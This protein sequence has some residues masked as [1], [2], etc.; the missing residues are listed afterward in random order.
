MPRA[1][2]AQVLF[3]MSLNSGGQVVALAQGQ[4]E[5]TEDSVCTTCFDS[6]CT[7]SSSIT[8]S[9]SS[10][11]SV[12]VTS[13]QPDCAQEKPKVKVNNKCP[14][15]HNRPCIFGLRGGPLKTNCF[16]GPFCDTDILEKSILDPTRRATLIRIYRTMVPSSQECALERIPREYKTTFFRDR[17]DNVSA[18]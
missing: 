10:T 2:N 15:T 7:S 16:A 8:S 6:E 18:P 1:N 14:G 3:C 5:D 12:S 11:S 13:P 9:S 4:E 17:T